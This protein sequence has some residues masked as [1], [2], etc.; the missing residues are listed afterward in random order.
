MGTQQPQIT[1]GGGIAAFIR[2]Q[3]QP[4]ST[5]NRSPGAR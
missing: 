2:Q 5:C 4:Q 1:R 3:I